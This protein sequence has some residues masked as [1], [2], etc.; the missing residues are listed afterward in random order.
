MQ[1]VSSSSATTSAAEQT[2]A[3]SGANPLSFTH[4]EMSTWMQFTNSLKVEANQPEPVQS[5]TA[6][7]QSTSH[8]SHSI[9][10]IPPAFASPSATRHSTAT[11]HHTP[12]HHASPPRTTNP[13]TPSRSTP[14]IYD[15]LTPT[16]ICQDH[17]EAKRHRLYLRIR[18]ERAKRA[19]ERS[20]SPAA[21][22]HTSD[23]TA[24]TKSPSPITSPQHYHVAP[25]QFRN[26]LKHSHSQSQPQFGREDISNSPQ[27]G[28]LYYNY[29]TGPSV[30]GHQHTVNTH[31]VTP[32]HASSSTPRT[33]TPRGALRS[34]SSRS[35]VPRSPPKTLVVS[36][37]SCQH[38]YNDLQ[39]C[40][41]GYTYPDAY[42]G[43]ASSSSST[44]YWKYSTSNMMPVPTVPVECY[45][46]HSGVN[47]ESDNEPC[48]PISSRNNNTYTTKQHLTRRES[49]AHR[50]SHGYRS[51]TPNERMVRSVTP[52][53]QQSRFSPSDCDSI[54][55]ST[56]VVTGGMST[57]RHHSGRDS[58]TPLF[59][60]PRASH[61]PSSTTPK[62]TDKTRF[63]P[64]PHQAWHYD[65]QLAPSPAPPLTITDNYRPPSRN[66]TPTPTRFSPSLT[67]PIR[68]NSTQQA[69]MTPSKRNVMHQRQQSTRRG[70][71]HL[72]NNTGQSSAYQHSQTTT[73][74]NHTNGRA[75]SPPPGPAIRSRKKVTMFEPISPP[76]RSMSFQKDSL[77]GFGD[78]G[79]AQ[80]QQPV[81]QMTS[82]YKHRTTSPH[83]PHHHKPAAIDKDKDLHEIVCRMAGITKDLA[84][85]AGQTA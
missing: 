65:P 21:H 41:C 54:A 19:K 5:S 33:S 83:K 44:P 82:T 10:H 63:S 24:W 47:V 16:S 76:P 49:T 30:T 42:A 13:I 32:R 45:P 81:Q 25:P 36:P 31:Q 2:H 66:G 73:H 84:Q 3:K 7:H 50:N 22:R 62:V 37:M 70:S 64:T 27:F 6:S 68:P 14:S 55:S 8:Q 20:R 69:T 77:L 71:T 59:S 18:A 72:H 29:D 34:R 78:V 12:T 60:P 79:F 23:N 39:Y 57:P 52:T 56:L 9:L 15:A 1:T 85:K 26:R 48:T 75:V 35:S 43:S 46:N 40:N 4:D 28:D 61:R 51:T 80:Q 58:T 67:T 53:S 38:C 74:N 17:A 11:T